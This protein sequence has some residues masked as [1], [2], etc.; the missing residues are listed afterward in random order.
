MNGMYAVESS[1]P[2]KKKKKEKEKKAQNA[3]KILKFRRY[4]QTGSEQLREH[5]LSGGFR[6]GSR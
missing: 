3:I 6:N 5:P 2:K 4:Q 1:K